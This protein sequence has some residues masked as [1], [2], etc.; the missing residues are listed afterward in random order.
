MIIQIAYVVDDL[1]EAMARWQTNNL[2]GPFFV[3]ED[4][5]F[6][7]PM[8]RGE[9]VE[10]DVDIAMSSS[11]GMNIE[12]IK[13]HCDTPSIYKEL[14]DRSGGGFHH[15][16]VSSTDIDGDVADHQAKGHELAFH[17]GLQAGGSFA[18]M[19][20]VEAL[21]GFV[22]LI[23]G[24]EGL[25]NMFAMIESAAADW[26]GTDPVRILRHRETPSASEGV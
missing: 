23:E 25:R 4:V 3:I 5:Q 8:H 26:D 11:G 6:V 24:G 2:A 13:Q 18:Y 16:G 7:D 19:D 15:W 20:T 17:A 22:E 21:G 14:R 1:N 12:L 9:P 10:L